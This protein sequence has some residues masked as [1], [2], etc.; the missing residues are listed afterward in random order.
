[1]R[2]VSFSFFLLFPVPTYI[3][4]AGGIAMAGL[5]SKAIILFSIANVLLFSS[6]SFADFAVS[7]SCSSNGMY[8]LD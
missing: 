5:S 3:V 7:D 8:I 4:S 6:F 2:A 1:M